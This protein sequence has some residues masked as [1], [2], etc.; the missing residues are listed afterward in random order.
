MYLKLIDDF[1]ECDRVFGPM[2]DLNSS[3]EAYFIEK[4]YNLLY[5]SPHNHHH[6]N[7]IKYL[8]S[9]LIFL[10]SFIYKYIKNKNKTMFIKESS[11]RERWLEVDVG[12][13]VGAQLTSPK[14]RD[15]LQQQSGV[16]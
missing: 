1:I 5:N 12:S 13:R 9:R 4:A 3:F 14:S 8:V 6:P 16:L 7:E 10:N 15:H 11:E 2:P